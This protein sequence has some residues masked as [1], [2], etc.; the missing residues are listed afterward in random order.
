MATLVLGAIGTAIGTSIGGSFLGMSAAAIGGFIGSSVGSMVDSAILMSGVSMDQTVEGNRLESLQVT[1]SSEGVVIPR[2]LGRYRVGG[3]LIWATDF[4]EERREDTQSSGG[5]KGGGGGGSSVTT[6]EYRYCASFAIAFGEGVIPTIGRIWADGK[7]ME[8]SDLTYRFYTGS[9]DQLPDPLIASTVGYDSAPAYRGVCY[10][11]FENLPLA[12]YANRIPQINVEVIRPIAEDDTLEG[13]AR[14]VT[15][16]PGS[17]EYVYATQEIKQ[18]G[19]SGRTENVN[20]ADGRA[21][22]LEALDQLQAS[23]PNIESVSL[24]VSW[25]G[26]DLRVGE[27]EVRPGVETDDKRTNVRWEVDGLRRDA[28]MVISTDGNGRPVY[29]GTPADFSVIEAI[30]EMKARGLRVTFYPF[31]MMDVVDGNDLPDPY[32][33]NAATLGQPVFPWRG[34]ITCSPAAGFAGTVDKT[35]AAA[36]QVDAFFERE[37]GI[38]RMILHYAEL[39]AEAGG[40]DSFLIGSEMRGLTQIRSAAGTYPAVAQYQQLAAD[41]R[42]FLP[43]AAISYAADWSEYFGHRPGDGSGDLYFHLDSLWADPNVDFIGIDNYMP[44]SDWRDGFDHLDAQDAPSIYDLDYLRSNIEGGEGFDWFYA[45]DADREAQVR[46]P[47]T[48]GAYGKPWVYRYKDLWSWWSEQHYNRPG[49]VEA[50]S[51]TAWVPGSKPFRFTE[52]GSPAIDRGPNQPNVFFDPKSSESMIPYHSRGWR[53]DAVQRAYLEATLTFWND[54]AKNPAATSYSGRMVDMSEASIWT[55]DARPFPFFPALEDV[56]SDGENWRLGHWMTGRLGSLSLSAL[57]RHLCVRAGVPAERIDASGLWGA[58]EGISSTTI[59]SPRSAISTLA[60][61]FGFDAT[62]SGGRVVFRMRG[63]APVARLTV[64]DLVAA[65]D[66]EP[67]SIERAQETELPQILKW[68]FG[69]GDE[70]YSP[71]QVEA[72]RAVSGTARVQSESFPMAVSPEVGTQRCRRALQ[73]AWAGRE[74]ASFSLPPSRM[75]LD[76]T[77]VLSLDH[78]GRD[79]DLQIVSLADGEARRLDLIRRD[80]LAYDLPAGE[81]RERTSLPTPTV[82]GDLDVTFLNLPMLSSDYE[83]HVPF[84]AVHT[85]PWPGSISVIRMN[86][87]YTEFSSVGRRAIVAETFD[88]LERGPL[89]VWDDAN[90]LVITISSGQLTSVS[91]EALLYGENAFAIETGSGGWEVFQAANATLVGPN[92]YRLSRLLRGQRGTDGDMVDVVPE[93]ARLIVLD[94]ISPLPVTP[95]DIGRSASYR[96]RNGGSMLGFFAVFGGYLE[97]ESIVF[98]PTARGRQPF[99]PCHVKQP[100][101]TGRS[102]GDLTIEWVR[103]DRSLEADSWESREVPMSE[104]ELEFEVDIFDGETVL[105]TLSTSSTSVVYGQSQQVADFGSVLS[106]GDQLDVRIYQISR[107]YGR[108]APLI[109]TLLF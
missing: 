21:D 3:N 37:W 64:D 51:P 69:R 49:G 39:C 60:R 82:F 36:D 48:D 6:V 109:E 53:D 90:S 7:P 98:T 70:E 45:S 59:D 106:P 87:P 103:R 4:T 10:M 96:F 2:P 12:D 40:V 97:D 93:G 108:G 86:S 100:Y 101:R 67:F 41:V 50:A 92:S 74:T 58:V 29:G 15:L 99:S 8:L 81:P 54:P 62:E 77:D 88:P 83:D 56:W 42:V 32:S 102:T 13:L 89:G 55:W 107:T 52:Y 105:R 61:H 19:S 44:I 73:E 65:E 85:N 76:A 14:S 38:R 84:I 5:G 24:V 66:G 43:S 80:R 11:V 95:S 18:S 68:A 33:D 31:I 91:D 28:V 25:F 57:V 104:E 30:Q 9:E 72:R 20:S 35:A 22:I 27:C 34:R 16:I 71:T 17:G 78:D 26:N 46:T 94:T 23:A 79:Y 75:G 1:T 47:I 63:S